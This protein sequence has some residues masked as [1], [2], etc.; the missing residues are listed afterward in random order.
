L[1]VLAEVLVFLCCSPEEDGKC[2]LQTRNTG[3]RGKILLVGVAE[4]TEMC[5]A[6]PESARQLCPS[7]VAPQLLSPPLRG[8]WLKKNWQETLQAQCFMD[9]TAS[10]LVMY[11]RLYL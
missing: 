9:H 11:G 3:P 5:H 7:P 2:S 4:E 1:D 8:K 10:E 6:R